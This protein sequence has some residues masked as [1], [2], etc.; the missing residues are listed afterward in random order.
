MEG[1]IHEG[2]AW[3]VGAVGVAVALYIGKVALLLLAAL[4]T[5]VKAMETGLIRD[6]LLDLVKAAEAAIKSEGAGP[7]KRALVQEAAKAAGLM[8]TEL[9][10]E[11]A[12]HEMKAGF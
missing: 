4:K 11:A 9:D 1:L 5:K 2:Y 7:Q 6:I 10:I 8:I 12:V 3:L